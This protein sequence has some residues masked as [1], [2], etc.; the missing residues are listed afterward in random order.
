MEEISRKS[1]SDSLSIE[2]LFEKVQNYKRNVE[3]LALENYW[4]REFFSQTAPQVVKNIDSVLSMTPPMFNI[5]AKKLFLTPQE[6]DDDL[7]YSHASKAF[8]LMSRRFTGGS[9]LLTPSMSYLSRL[10]M[11][12][13]IFVNVEFKVELCEESTERLKIVILHEQKENLEKLKNL[14]AQIQEVEI[15]RKELQNAKHEFTKVVIEQSI[16]EMTN[17]ISP[18]AIEKFLNDLIKNGAI[19]VDSI[20]L[21]NGTMTSEYKKKKKLLKKHKELSSCLRP[22]DFE[23]AEIEKKNFIK[24][25]EE[26]RKHY[27]GLKYEEREAALNKGKEHKILLKATDELKNVES[28]ITICDESIAKLKLAI[29]QTEEEIE[30]LKN[31]INDLKKKICRFNAPTI[32]ESINKI[33]DYEEKKNEL[34]KAK[35]HEAIAKIKLQNVKM[36]YQEQIEINKNYP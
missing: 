16:D 27:F 34:K 30:H 6:F 17:Q 2:K 7:E 8:R 4:I 15:D 14:R 29:I 31:S 36:K 35:R 33:N 13:A 18:R 23:L 21:K 28:K 3:L 12:M 5:K 10:S 19:M 22:I 9:E 24:L 25:N 1:S 26:K 32:V 11:T 20:R